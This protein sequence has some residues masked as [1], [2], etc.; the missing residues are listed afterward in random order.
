[1]FLTDRRYPYESEKGSITI[2][3]FRSD[4]PIPDEKED[5][6]RSMDTYK[7]DWVLCKTEEDFNI[8]KEFQPQYKD[9]VP[10]G[11]FSNFVRTNVS[12]NCNH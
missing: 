6:E 9:F 7:C 4:V 11:E 2:R 1:M 3:L 5:S 8:L 12:T 10:H